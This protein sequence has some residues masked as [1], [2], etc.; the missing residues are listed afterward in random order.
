M[1]SKPSRN[2]NLASCKSRPTKRRTKA[3]IERLKAAI[4]ET[5]REDKPMTVRQVFY[6]LVSA[7]VIDK[8][9]NEYKNSVG[10]LLVA[11]RREKELPFAWIADNTR[12]MRKPTTH[13]CL[14]DALEL[15]ARTYRRA[16][17]D[18][19]DAYV[20]IWTEKDALAGVL[21]EE[22]KLWD[23]PL[24]VSRGFASIS[25]LY[26]AAEVISDKDKPAFLYYLGDR[27]PSGVHIDRV[28]EQRLRELAPYAEIHFQRVAVR[29]EQISQWDLPTRPTKR[30][31]SRCKSFEGQS[32]EVDAI[33]PRQ[34]REIV[35]Q[36]IEQHVDRAQLEVTRD[37]EKGEKDLLR[38]LIAALGKGAK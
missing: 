12:W 26:E 7:G 31:D 5:V 13:S 20:E 4:Y 8:T 6:R 15:T 14:D 3:D 32:V 36:C 17:W 19:Q 27:D 35:R 24:M 25:Y 16:L 29:P 28:I 9:E 23:V 18:D 2:G 21:Y 34:L 10:R 1:V 11:M 22:T 30:T 33:P 38:A 37:I